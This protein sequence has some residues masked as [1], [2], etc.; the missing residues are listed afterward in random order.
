MHVYGYIFIDLFL[1]HLCIWKS[2]E[3]F[4]VLPIYTADCLRGY[5]VLCKQVKQSPL[6]CFL[7][8]NQTQ[9]FNISKAKIH[10]LNRVWNTS[11]VMH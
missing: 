10:A 8:Q 1:A 9:N 3:G 6:N 2:P 7:N 5:F 4:I 11:K